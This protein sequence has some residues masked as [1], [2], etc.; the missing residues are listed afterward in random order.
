MTTQADTAEPATLQPGEGHLRLRQN[1]AYFFGWFFTL[2]FIYAQLWP[3]SELNAWPVWIMAI[4]SM[5]IWAHAHCKLADRPLPTMSLWLVFLVWPIA[6]PACVV[7]ANGWRWGTMLVLLHAGIYI[8]IC[9]IV[10]LLI[11][12]A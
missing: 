6:V 5:T 9:Y 10:T 8:T 1:S 7:R 12:S 11:E 3:G 2:L 4:L